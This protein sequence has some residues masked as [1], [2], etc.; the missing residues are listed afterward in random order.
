MRIKMLCYGHE[1]LNFRLLHVVIEGIAAVVLFCLEFMKGAL[2]IQKTETWTEEMEI[3][4]QNNFFGFRFM[5]RS[6]EQEL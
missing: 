2:E 6:S 1:F 4:R 3:G 5:D